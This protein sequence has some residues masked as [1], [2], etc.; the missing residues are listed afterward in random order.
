MAV[1]VSD[2]AP[3]NYLVLIEAAGLLPRLYQRVL[4]PPSVFLELIHPATPGVVRVWVEQRPE[5][6]EVATP[7]SRPAAGLSHLDS[8]EAQAITLALECRADVLLMDE[9]DGSA[10]ARALGLAVTG[11]L[12]VL[13]SAA[14]LGW[15]DL[16][17]MF[18]RLRLTTFRCP[19][20]LMATM[21]EQD[22]IRRQLEAPVQP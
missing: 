6:L 12:G 22:A 20:R 11:T 17:A 9:R 1:I 16:S 10:S 18:D 7:A 2:T 15:A 13:D 8:G 5:W 14:R 3:L 19:V 21:L 4:I